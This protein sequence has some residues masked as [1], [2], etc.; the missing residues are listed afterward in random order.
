MRSLGLSL[1]ASVRD[2][3]PEAQMVTLLPLVVHAG[4]ERVSKGAAA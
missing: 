1:S 3:L 4:E 2:R